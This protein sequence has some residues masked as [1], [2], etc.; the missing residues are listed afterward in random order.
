MS[1]YSLSIKDYRIDFH[2][3]NVI[4]EKRTVTKKKVK[5]NSEINKL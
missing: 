3:E 1:T 4:E 5:Q 2:N